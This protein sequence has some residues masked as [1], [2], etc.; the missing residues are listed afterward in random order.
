LFVIAEL[1]PA[2]TGERFVPPPCKPKPSFV[3]VGLGLAMAGEGFVPPPCKPKPSFVMA[4]LDPATHPRRQVDGA[5][6]T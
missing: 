2:M 4:G 1:D 3:M 6:L 5:L